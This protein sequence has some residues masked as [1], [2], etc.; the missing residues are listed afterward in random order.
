MRYCSN[1]TNIVLN[2][3]N[4]KYKLDND[5]VLLSF[6]GSELICCP[7]GKNITSYTIPST[8]TSIANFAFSSCEKLTSITIASGV[9]SIG[10]YAFE[11]CSGITN[12]SIPD[13]VTILDT[14][15]VFRCTSLTSVT[16]GDGITSIGSDAFNSCSALTTF[17]I[18]ATTPPSLGLSAFG[19]CTNLTTIYVP[20]ESIA[21]TYKAELLSDGVTSNP[22]HS[23]ESMIKVKP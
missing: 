15:A 11:D 7:A 13:S 18:S 6:D 1:L 2:S 20:S 12:L 5:G 4:T 8:V 10:R 16:I 14:G 9:T 23:Y 21:N 19:E 17:T 22:W 3:G